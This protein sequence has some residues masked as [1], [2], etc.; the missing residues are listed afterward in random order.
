MNNINFSINSNESSISSKKNTRL[1]PFAIHT[2]TFDGAEIKEG[3]SKAG[4]EFKLLQLTFSNKE[5]SAE[6]SIFWPDPER[7]GIREVRKA[8]DG[9]EYERPSYFEEFKWTILQIA[10]VVNPA[11]YEKLKTQVVKCKTIDDFIKLVLAVANA[12]KD[13]T[14]KLKLTGREFNGSV[15]AQLPRVCGVDRQGN[16]FVANTFIGNNV[17]F[18]DYEER[19]AAEYANRKPTKNVED[20][21]KTDESDQNVAASIT[22]SSAADEGDI[23]FEGLLND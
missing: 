15:F 23:D 6:M 19:K 2:V 10:S 16:C 21:L 20:L 5:G 22:Q 1:T 17:Y 12:K 14:V 3:T 7:D 18:S 4:N 8:K 11:G 13:A 9:H